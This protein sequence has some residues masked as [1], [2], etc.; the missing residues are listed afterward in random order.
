MAFNG[1][2][3]AAGPVVFKRRYGWISWILKTMRWIVGILQGVG[4]QGDVRMKWLITGGAG[5]IGTNTA[6]ALAEAGE[7]GGR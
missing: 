3:R 7:E 2:D 1:V 5:F 4:G 6:A